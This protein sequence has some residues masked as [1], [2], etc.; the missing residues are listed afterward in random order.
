MDPKLATAGEA[1]SGHAGPAKT[2][3]VASLALPA[4]G[5]HGGGRCMKSIRLSPALLGPRGWSPDVVDLLPVRESLSRARSCNFLL[6]ASTPE[7]GGNGHES[8]GRGGAGWQAEATEP[9]FGHHL[10]W[11]EPCERADS[12]P[13]DA[14]SSD[15]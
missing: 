15:E 6:A 10:A 9:D 11:T 3:E 8:D 4:R 14:G 13:P 5:V 7:H 12:P 1:K 2:P